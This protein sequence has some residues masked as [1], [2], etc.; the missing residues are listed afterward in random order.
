MRCRCAKAHNGIPPRWPANFTWFRGSG[1]TTSSTPSQWFGH[2][3]IVQQ[4][5]P[6]A[7]AGSCA[8]RPCRR[9]PVSQFIK[10]AALLL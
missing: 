5:A 1:A 4:Q 9:Q 6:R 10:G 2:L 7:P 3:Q 8:H